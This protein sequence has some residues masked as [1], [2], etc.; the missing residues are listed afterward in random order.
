MDNTV[1]TLNV[2]TYKKYFG[3]KKTIT[4]VRTHY[5]QTHAHKR[6]SMYTYVNVKGIKERLLLN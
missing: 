5:T 3:K 6:K 2:L 1:G 4:H